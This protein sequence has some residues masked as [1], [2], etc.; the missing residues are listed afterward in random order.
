MDNH[1]N[2]SFQVKNFGRKCQH[3]PQ[4]IFSISVFITDKIIAEKTLN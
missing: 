2:K 3:S 4:L 1:T